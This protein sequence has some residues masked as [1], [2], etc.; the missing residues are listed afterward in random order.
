MTATVRKFKSARQNGN[1]GS[2]LAQKSGSL[3][4]FAKRGSLSRFSWLPGRAHRPSFH[5]PV[6]AT[7]FSGRTSYSGCGTPIIHLSNS[8][9][10]AQGARCDARARRNV[11]AR[12]SRVENHHG[13]WPFQKL[14]RAEQLFTARIL[15]SAVVGFAQHKQDRGVNMLHKCNGGAAGIVLRI[16]EGRCFEP[17]WLKESEIG[18]VPP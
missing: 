18:G 14:E 11:R 2:W 15:R 7:W 17:M 5:G 9:R 16:L 10:C 8:P 4:S 3:S 1:V 13:G 12:E 6:F